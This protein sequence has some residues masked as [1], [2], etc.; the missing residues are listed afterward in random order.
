M[1]D[2]STKY[3]KVR[4][5]ST[6][7]Y[8]PT[9]EINE[10]TVNKYCELKTNLGVLI[11]RY[12]EDGI[13]SKNTKSIS[14]YKSGNIRSISLNERTIV[15]TPIGEIKAEL[16]TFYENG[17]L[18]RLFPLNGKITAYWTEKNEYELAEE[19]KFNFQFG[20]LKNK[21]ICINFYD[22]G[23][24]KSLTFWSKDTVTIDTPNGKMQVRI[25]ISTYEDG[26]L[27]TCEPASQVN[28]DTPIGSITAYD[29]NAL[30]INGDKNSLNFYENGR[31]KSLYTSTDMI[32][33]YNESG[34][35]AAFQPKL[36]PSIFNENVMDIV[37][38]NIEFYDG[39]VRFN[40]SDEASFEINKYIFKISK[41]VTNITKETNNCTGCSK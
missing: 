18:K 32:E 28:V 40:D 1:K 39:K 23:Q 41:G 22:S 29:I 12:K 6:A 8:Y 4:G 19:L 21:V 9:G 31:V 34:C 11:P 7:Y 37:P 25:G 33:V 2:F 38:F 26:K 35:V 15:P 3:G 16:I 24:V 20:R 30:G 36:K 27:K 13:R 10:C 5:V 17:N 14:F